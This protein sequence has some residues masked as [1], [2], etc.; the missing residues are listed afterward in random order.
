MR[1]VSDSH[2][3]LWYL[4]ADGQLSAAALDALREA[5]DDEGIVVSVATLMDLWYVTQTTRAFSGDDLDQVVG[6]LHDEGVNIHEA[7]IGSTTAEKF[8][9]LPLDSLRD[10]WDRLIVATAVEHR[11]PLVTRDRAITAYLG[12]LGAEP[13]SA[14]W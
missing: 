1:V 10:P 6:L 4:R 13:V 12:S 5:E 14:V 8:R 11:L 3:L 9:S 2:A 7:P